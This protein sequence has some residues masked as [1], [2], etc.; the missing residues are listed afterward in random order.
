MMIAAGRRL[1]LTPL[2]GVQAIAEERG[3]WLATDADPQF[4][5]AIDPQLGGHWVRLQFDI[6]PCAGWASCPVLYIDCG[7]GYFDHS[8][9]RL[10]RPASGHSRVDYVFPLSEGVLRAR[11]DPLAQSGRFRLGA[12]SI[13]RLSKPSAGLVMALAVLKTC[14]PSEVLGA[15]ARCLLPRPSGRG[16]RKFLNWVVGKY[17]AREKTQA[18]ADWIAHFEPQPW[19]YASLLLAERQWV[20]PPLISILMPVYNTSAPLL[21]AAVESVRA[22]L[23]EHWELCIA[24]DA[25]TQPHVRQMLEQFARM[26]PR[27][28]VA[29]RK[30]NGHI[31]AASN[32]ALELA[33]GRFVALLDHDDVLHPLALHFVAEAIAQCPDAGLVYTDE[34]KIDEAGHRFDPYFKCE[35]NYELMLAQNMVSHLGVY[36]RS[37]VLQLGGFRAGYEGSQDYDLA[38]RVTELLRADQ[39]IHVPRVLY[40]W[41]ATAG[42]TA[43]AG[44]EKPYA[45]VAARTAVAH[46]LVRRGVAAEVK[47]AP[48]APDYHRVQFRLPDQLPLVSIIIPTRDRA[49]L[50]EACIMSLLERTTYPRFEIIIV[51]NQSSRPETIALFKQVASERIRILREDST[52]NFSRLNNLAAA[53]AR[54]SYLCLLN[55]DIEVITPGWLEEMVSFAAL[56]GVGAV[57]ARLWYPDGTLQHGGVILG[58]GGVASHSHKHLK[59][60]HPGYFGRAV[61]H[62]SFSAV[63]AA[64][65]VM[66]KAIY[67]TL[68]GMDEG[69]PVA[70]NDIDLCLRARRQG[71]RNVWTPYA[72]MIHHESASRGEDAAP[73]KRK[74]LM[75]EARIFEERWR[76][77]LVQDPAYSPNLTLDTDDFEIA[78]PP[79]IQLLGT[80]A[81]ASA[82]SIQPER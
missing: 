6:E 14:G 41:R 53:Q 54:G 67:D 26:D 16:L 81:L 40:H 45:A 30:Q 51:D 38:L 58:V 5:V 35:F 73:E 65:L 10:P 21:K 31:A 27:I 47:A 79:R 57:G 34:D 55:N 13:R 74:R 12:V 70:F 77:E 59:R 25:S 36:R 4:E 24:D 63:T 7:R 15:A 39:V 29:L 2:S 23:Y 43:L 52:F 72:E 50:L 56:D 32:S 82:A 75:D 64:C 80:A 18:Y 19:S 11:L 9:V 28:K 37:L 8:A 61:L 68:G 42:S 22:Q 44:Q 78:W 69:L 71:L 49:D 33:T 60:G 62:Q 17:R 48:E 3:E 46:H 1:A 20:D 76:N 66:R